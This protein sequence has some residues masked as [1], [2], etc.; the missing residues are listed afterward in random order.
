MIEVPLKSSDLFTDK[1]R[2]FLLRFYPQAWLRRWFLKRS[3]ADS[4]PFSYNPNLAECQRVLVFLPR[5]EA[6]I[7]V[8]LPLLLE[9][10]RGKSS[11]SLLLITDESHRHLLRALGLEPFAH[12][13]T[14]TGMRYGESEFELVSRQIQA[15]QWDLCLYLDH[16]FPLTLLFLAK[17]SMATYRMGVG[18]EAHFPFLNISLRPSQPD[19]PYSLRTLL[20][21]QF[22][23]NPLVVSERALEAGKHRSAAAQSDPVH[24]SSSNVLLINLEPPLEGPAWSVEEITRLSEAFASKFRLLALVSHPE[25]L[26]PF[27]EALENLKVRT[28]PVPSTSGALFDMLRQYKGVVTLNTAHAHLFT[29]LSPVRVVVLAGDASSPWALHAAKHVQ[30]YARDM[31][32]YTLAQSVSSFMLTSP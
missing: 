11:D 18:C 4:G 23:L 25:Q 9:I 28:A 31:D 21:Q 22:R 1:F 29:N 12:F 2:Y 32:P 13:G 10:A 19:S 8:L 7:F 15:H 6:Q 30:V 24:L 26:A 20:Y 27:A 16:G 3:G 17:I 14:S 5:Q